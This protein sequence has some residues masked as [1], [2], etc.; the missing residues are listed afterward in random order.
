MTKTKTLL[1]ATAALLSTGCVTRFYGQPTVPNGP[2]G[3]WEQCQA[4][5]MDLAGMVKMGE[6]SDGCICQVRPPPGTSQQAPQPPASRSAPQSLVAPVGTAVVAA[7]I[8]MQEEEERRSG[9]AYGPGPGFGG[10]P[11]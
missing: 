5:G 3:C 9:G 10:R 1:A 4:W 6:Y 7:W 8:A 2:R 11:R